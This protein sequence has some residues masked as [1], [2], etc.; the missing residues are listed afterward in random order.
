MFGVRCSFVVVCC[1]GVIGCCCLFV[2][3]VCLLMFV[4]CCLWFVVGCW[5]LFVVCCLGVSCSSCVVVFYMLFH[6]LL[7][8]FVYGLL[9]VVRWI[10]GC[11]FLLV[12]CCLVLVVGCS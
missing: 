2:V 12:D 7:I 1:V 5:L 8:V 3:C 9:F 11:C 4:V 6:V 10:F